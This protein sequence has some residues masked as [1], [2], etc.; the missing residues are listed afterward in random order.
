MT[1][2]YSAVIFKGGGGA[3]TRRVQEVGQVERFSPLEQKKRIQKLSHRRPLV[4]VDNAQSICDPLQFVL[5]SRILSPSV[6]TVTPILGCNLRKKQHE[7]FCF[8]SS[9]FSTAFVPRYIIL[10]ILACRHRSTSF[11][12]YAAEILYLPCLCK[13]S[14]NARVVD[15]QETM[16]ASFEIY[17]SKNGFAVISLTSLLFPFFRFSW[18]WSVEFTELSAL[19]S[20]G[21]SRWSRF[22]ADKLNLSGSSN[23]P[24]PFWYRV[25]DSSR[26]HTWV[27]SEMTSMS[28]LAPIKE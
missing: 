16:S 7:L 25:V 18:T 1:V 4:S 23:E 21:F 13:F 8:V 22:P 27:V 10:W 24:K 15:L 12:R 6:L 5:Q 14:R 9:D 26:P 11:T 19:E 2:E 28:S 17:I 20:I 3:I